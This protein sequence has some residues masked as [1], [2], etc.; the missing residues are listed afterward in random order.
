M[1]HLLSKEKYSKV[2]RFYFNRIL[3]FLCKSAKLSMNFSKLMLKSRSTAKIQKLLSRLSDIVL[4]V[5][6]SISFILLNVLSHVVDETG[7]HTA[8]IRDVIVG[9]PCFSGNSS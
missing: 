4:R 2:T 6:V 9:N 7:S 3:R 8:I 5:V 1:I